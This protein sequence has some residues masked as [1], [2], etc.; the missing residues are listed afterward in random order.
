MA[1]PAPRV[2]NPTAAAN[3]RGWLALAEK[4]YARARLA[5]GQTDASARDE[6][7]WLFLRTLRWPLDS[8]ER[9]LD[10]P[11]TPAQSTALATVLRRRTEDRVPA[12]YLLREAWL[13]GEKFYV[14]ERVLIPRS[15]FV[16]ILPTLPALLPDGVKVRRAA[17]VCTGSGCLAILLAKQF[18]GATVDATDLSPSALAVARRNIRAHRLARRVRPVLADVLEPVSKSARAAPPARY[19]L[20]LS[21]PPYEPSA[22][23]D[24]LPAEFKQEP[25]LALDGGTDGLDII[26]RL[27]RQAR[28]RLAPGGLLLIEVGGLRRAMAREFKPLRL[29]WLPT[30]DGSDCVCL[31]RAENLL[32]FFNAKARRGEGANPNLSRKHEGT[33]TRMSRI[34]P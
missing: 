6:A 10:R 26:R 16:E 21:N 4:T 1:R 31:A 19:D 24:R 20:I 29:E 28:D 15:Y 32:N 33:E 3:L 22:I 13:G 12:A 5:L 18:P 2:P 14:D 17:D 8:D 27:F 9:S 34:S 23:C 25:R 30:A 7:L 11:L